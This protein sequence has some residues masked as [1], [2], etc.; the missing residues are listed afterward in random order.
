MSTTTVLWRSYDGDAK[1]LDFTMPKMMERGSGYSDH[2][3]VGIDNQCTEVK[4]IC[5]KNGV[6]FVPDNEAAGIP[7][8]YINQ[9]YTKLRADQFCDTDYVFYMDSDVECLEEHSVDVLFRNEKPLLLYTDWED[10]GDAK[11]WKAPTAK[12]IR[13]DPQYEFMRRIPLLYPTSVVRDCREFMELLH[14][15]TLMQYMNGET[16]I[17]EFN[18]LGAY[19]WNY[20]RD[21]FTWTNTAH[22]DFEPIP[23]KQFWSWGNMKQQ[24]EAYHA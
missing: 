24:L 23:F 20:R 19:A 18:I 11:C 12:A 8:G 15:K 1:W 2:V 5:D 9:Q 7:D 4:K 10:V 17:S 14:L 22:N 6:R 16:S 3:V 21:L 13:I